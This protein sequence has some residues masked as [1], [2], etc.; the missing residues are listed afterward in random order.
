MMLGAGGVR[1]AA[2]RGATNQSGGDRRATLAARRVLCGAPK[3]EPQSGSVCALLGSREGESVA[4]R[5]GK[6]QPNKRLKL[7]APGLGRIPFVPQRTSCAC[8]NVSA[9]AGRGAAA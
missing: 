6:G 1:R 3:V 5:S 9:P 8:V 7:T 2:R 4:E